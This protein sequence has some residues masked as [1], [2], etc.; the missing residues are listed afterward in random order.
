MTDL[1]AIPSE[2]VGKLI[3]LALGSNSPGECFAA[4][5]AIRRTLANGGFD[6]HWLAGV[7]EKAWPI[8]CEPSPKPQREPNPKKPWQILADELLKYANDPRIVWGSKERDFL[9]NMRRSRYA[10]TAGQEKWMRDINAR[11]GKAAA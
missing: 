5:D 2:R 8:P 6:S 9:N 4:V 10:P 1:F 7:V 3:R 11:R